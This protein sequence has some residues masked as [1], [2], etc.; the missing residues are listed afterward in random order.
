[1]KRA[2]YE[3]HINKLSTLPTI[4]RHLRAGRLLPD[5]RVP[6]VSQQPAT[7][8]PCHRR[9]RAIVHVLYSASRHQVC[10]GLAYT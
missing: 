8:P 7:A 1:M 5:L 6:S 4:R 3:F 2:G 9:L 10:R